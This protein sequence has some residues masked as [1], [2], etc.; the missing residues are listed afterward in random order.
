MTLGERGASLIKSYETL[1]LKAYMPTVNDVPTI[2]WGHTKGV[3]MGQT[4][5]IITAET[6]FH[7]DVMVYEAL[8]D[9]LNI[10]LTQSQY[11]ALVSM[12]FNCGTLGPSITSALKRSAYYMACQHMFLWRKQEGT[13][14]L[15]LARRRAREMVLYL[16]DGL[17]S[18]T[19]T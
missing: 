17:P 1:R 6:L 2:G 10:P 19:T 16:E 13:D 7:E 4:I 12:A 3:T 11:D 15:G 14:L 9:H 18:M 8:V 5:D